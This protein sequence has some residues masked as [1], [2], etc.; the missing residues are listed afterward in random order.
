[1]HKYICMLYLYLDARFTSSRFVMY[2]GFL[3]AE[4]A[5]HNSAPFERGAQN[6]NENHPI[7]CTILQSSQNLYKKIFNHFIRAC[8]YLV[9]MLNELSQTSILYVSVKGLFPRLSSRPRR[10][11][12]GATPPRAH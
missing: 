5:L 6:C 12:L 1:M 3:L 8:A 9:F 11:A 10:S 2:D 4:R 7:R